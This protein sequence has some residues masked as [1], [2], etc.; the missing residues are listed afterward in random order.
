MSFNQRKL[1]AVIVIFSKK[2]GVLIH[3]ERIPKTTK[4]ILNSARDE[5]TQ[6]VI[7]ER[8]LREGNRCQKMIKGKPR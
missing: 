1:Q 7:K 6:C 4:L 5:T 3:E 8:G 2:D